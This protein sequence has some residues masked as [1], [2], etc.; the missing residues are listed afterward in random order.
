MTLVSAGLD[1]FDRE[2]FVTPTT[3]SC[4][5]KMLSAARREH[6][7]LA[8]VSAFRSV[9]YQCRLIRE[10]LEKGLD[11]VDIVRVNAIPG[12]SEHHTG[13][14]IDITT[15]GCKPLSIDFDQ[16]LAFEWLISNAGEFNFSMSYAKNNSLGIDYEPWHW[17]CG[18]DVNQQY[19]T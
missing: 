16:T 15:S 9:D 11:I 14:A 13:R 12:F 6:I 17:A 2:Q 18:T 4:W 8:L 7:E 10:K 3:L 5:S 19:T 1:I